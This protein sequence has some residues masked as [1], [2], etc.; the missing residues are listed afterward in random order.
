MTVSGQEIPIPGERNIRLS[1]SLS[2][3][4]K[5]DQRDRLQEEKSRLLMRPKH[6]PL[7]RDYC[8]G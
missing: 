4:Q 1:P 8:F 2:A 5:R 6:L 7:V 3:D